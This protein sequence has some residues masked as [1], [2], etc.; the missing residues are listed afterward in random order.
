MLDQYRVKVTSAAIFCLVGTCFF[1]PIATSLF[2]LFSGATILLW[3]FSGRI[4][5]LAHVI[6]SHST[7][8]ISTILFLFFV[9]GC[10]Y[11]SV[12]WDESLDTLKKYRE[13]AI[14]PLAVTLL[15]DNQAAQK[16]CENAFLAGS[17]VIMIL[18]YCMFFGLIPTAKYGYSFLYHISHSFFMSF[19]GFVSAHKVMDRRES[20]NRIF[21]GAVLLLC[22]ANM[23]Y[24]GTGRTGL[25]IFIFLMVLF[26]MQR[27]SLLKQIAGIVVIAF[28]FLV[29]Y[30]TSDTFHSRSEAAFEEV[31]N[32]EYGASR[33][34]LGMRLDWYVSSYNLV[35][36]KP[37]LGHGTGSFRQQ[38]LRAIWWT[39]IMET[40]NPHNEYL[41]ISVQLGIAGLLVF[42]A[43]LGSQ[44]M[45]GRKLEE[46]DRFY[47]QGIIVA[48]SIGCLGNSF[49]FDTHQGH[50]WALLSAIYLSKQLSAR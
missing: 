24:V 13:L 23:F 46:P 22:V 1:L 38:H 50:F 8:F 4:T 3:L 16:K 33:T 17:I 48:M 20:L 12:G 11:S 49:L 10:I 47:L 41:L 39:K 25:L 42:L 35:M 18:S 26:L 34:S 37:L 5:L 36:K 19:L 44:L 28:L 31:K 43:L 15:Y 40:D 32:Y 45:C 21:W 7:L 2:S 6:R 29:A 27:F 30:S 14:L 9:I